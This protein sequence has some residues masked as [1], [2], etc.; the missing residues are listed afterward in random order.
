MTTLKA[1]TL[2]INSSNEVRSNGARVTVV[3]LGV[4]CIFETSNTKVGTLTESSETG[5]TA[6]LDISATIPR[7]G[8]GGGIFCG[9]SA[10]WTGSY[11]VNT[12][13]TL[14]VD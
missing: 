12:P 3:H 14:N 9:S 13:D 7:V 5:A 10:P 11:I 6:T 4:H 8:G 1:G 2:S